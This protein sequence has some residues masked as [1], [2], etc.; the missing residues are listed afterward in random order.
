MTGGPLHVSTGDWTPGVRAALGGGER[1]EGVL[2]P[3][4]RCHS[5]IAWF[6]AVDGTALRRLIIP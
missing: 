6:V 1:I 4:L 2:E 3:V 5:L